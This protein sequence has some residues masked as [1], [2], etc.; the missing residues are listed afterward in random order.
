MTTMVP[1]LISM[2]IISM[3]IIVTIYG[4]KV[5]F[6]PDRVPR[7]IFQLLVSPGDEPFKLS[8]IEPDPSTHL[9]Y[10]YGDTIAVLF[11]QS[12]FVASRTNHVISFFLFNSPGINLMMPGVGE[13]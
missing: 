8:T 7:I 6:F 10:I 4:P 12:R 2:R 13:G 3:V 9:A 11:F 5:F 1:M